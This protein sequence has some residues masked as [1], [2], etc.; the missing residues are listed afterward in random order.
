MFD[1]CCGVL[2]PQEI[3]IRTHSVD[4][5]ADARRRVHK[6]FDTFKDT[7]PRAAVER[8][9]LMTE[10]FKQTEGQLL[11]W[12]W[13][14]ALM[15]IAENVPLYI[16]EHEIVVGRANGE[17]GRYGLIYPELEG[18]FLDKVIDLVHQGKAPYTFTEDDEHIIREEILPY[19]KGRSFHEGLYLALPE[20][21]RRLLF[22]PDNIFVQRNIVTQTA[23]FRSSLQWIMDYEKV[24]KKGFKGIRQEAE[25]KLEALDVLDPHNATRKAPF[26]QAIIMVCDAVVLFARRYA[27]L[28]TRMAEEE[29]DAKRRQELLE[30]ADICSRVPENPAQTFREA[31]QSQ[32]MTQVFSRLEQKTGA[33]I[34]NG[35]MDQYFYP[36]YKKDKEEGRITDESVLEILECLWLNMAQFLDLQVSPTFISFNEGY[37]HWEALTIGGKTRD[38]RDAANELSYLILRSKR[39]FP[40]NYPDLV[41]RVHSLSPNRYVHEICET[42][43]EGSGFPKMLNDEEIIP[44]F[45]AKGASI[46]EANDY[47][48][49]GCTEVRMPNRDTYTSPCSWVNLAAV[50]EM[51]LNDGKIRIFGDEQFGPKTGDPRTFVTYD[52]L[53]KAYCAQQ[54]YVLKHVF[55]QQYVVDTLRPKYLATPLCSALHDLCMKECKDLHSGDIA[56]GVKLGY[57]DMIGF[58]TVIDSLAALKKLVY[59]D[60]KLSMA[61]YMDALDCNFEGKEVLRQLCLNAPKYGNND[62]YADSIGRQVEREAVKFSNTYRT[63]FGAE[64]DVRYV[65]LTSHIPLGK[66]IDATP[67]GRKRGEY[68]SEGSSASHGADVKGPTGILL[69]NAHTKN[70]GFKERAARLLNIKLTP[71]TVVGTEGTRKLTSLIRT[72]CDLKLWHLQFNIINRETL[73]AAQKDPQKYKSLLVR[74]AGYSAYFVDLSPELQN[75]I[76]ARTE[77]SF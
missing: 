60:K 49:S 40:L 74:V 47:A 25:E 42:I 43:K 44:L 12:R 19:W 15:H 68:L 64:L 73:L 48:G 63:A 13:A 33:V 1:A 7:V 52:D 36:F 9:R 22:S 38:G 30:I 29:P 50:L 17:S 32:W 23:T 56:G 27:A 14:K 76:I 69:S 59:E 71:A 62:T 3:R 58:G 53:W 54:E 57:Y 77:H 11:I 70:T 4:E 20:E 51:T 37:A 28:A 26:L 8:A 41:A 75:E 21:T 24:L 46:E 35:R 6:I 55:T 67:N 10:S 65:P 34:G 16:G 61:E 66:I 5:Q 45:I 39:E 18:G 2:T 72:F 31:V